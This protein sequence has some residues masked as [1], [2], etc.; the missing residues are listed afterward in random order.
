M[1]EDRIIKV[2]RSK[3]VPRSRTA[4]R[5]DVNVGGAWL[6]K[7][8]SELT[9]ERESYIPERQGGPIGIQPGRD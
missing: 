4:G 5:T 2:D 6:R 1:L 9:G 7:E 3:R 8:L